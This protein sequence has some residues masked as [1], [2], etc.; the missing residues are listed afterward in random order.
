MRRIFNRVIK[1][2]LNESVIK[3]NL[4]QEEHNWATNEGLKSYAPSDSRVANLI[5]VRKKE[6]PMKRPGKKQ[7]DEFT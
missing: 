2:Y 4:T 5:D 7:I 3:G 1:S 6:L